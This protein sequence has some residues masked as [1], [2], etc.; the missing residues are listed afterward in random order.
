MV[1]WSDKFLKRCSNAATIFLLLGGS[2]VVMGAGQ[3][4]CC[5]ALEKIQFS[6]NLPVVIIESVSGTKIEY[7]SWQ[8]VKFCTCTPPEVAGDSIQDYNGYAKAAGRGNSSKDFNKT[9]FKVE[10]QDENGDPVD[11]ELLGFPE[12]EDFIFYGPELDKTLMKNYIAYNIG[13]ASGEYA[14]RTQ[15]VEIFSM[16][17]GQPLSLDDYRGVYV[18]VEKMKRDKNRIDIEKMDDKDPSGGYIFNYDNDNYDADETV[19]GPFTNFGMNHPFVMKEP[20]EL[21]QEQRDYLT[22]YL[23]EFMQS[24]TS[25][26]WL[27]LPEDQSY[28]SYIDEESF[29]KYLLAVEITKNPD[30]Y[31]GST[32][33]H[34]D[35]DGPLEMG[36]MWDYNEAFGLC[37]GYPIDGWQ[38]EGES[39][40]GIAG[41]S[42]IS[43]N[44]F[45]FLI[46]EDQERCQVDET[47][48]VSFWYR[49]MWQDPSFRNAT[50]AIWKDL[51]AGDWSDESI[52]DIVNSAKDQLDQ[53]AVTRNYEAYS[54]ILLEGMPT[55][56][57]RNVWQNETDRVETWLFERLHW[58]DKALDQPLASYANFSS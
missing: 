12:E 14:S 29:I 16:E 3:G 9:Q 51:R 56:D 42:A 46:C 21:T 1:A 49:K 50:S 20:K 57:G 47:D 18:L 11:F 10:L 30:G 41:G 34:K 37:C 17:D 36:P 48:G 40:S 45:R 6:S 35:K 32:Y 13:R 22:R 23:N 26:N 24:L 52:M 5:A 44:G 43:P 54:D 15:F 8:Q 53:G 19:L 28:K 39:M 2:S 25:D 33:M 31:R 55:V 38:R 4:D 27:D 7:D 58:M